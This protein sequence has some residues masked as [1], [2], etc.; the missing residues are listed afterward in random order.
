MKLYT[1]VFLIVILVLWVAAGTYFL[2]F[3]HE[4][5]VELPAL[6]LRGGNANASTEFLNAQKTVDYY[7]EEIKKKPDVIK[8]YIELAQ[9][10]LQEARVTG[11]HHEYIPK[12]QSLLE[13]A[14]KRDPESYEANVTKA[15]M[16]MTMHQFE[17]AKKLAE[18]TV[19]QRPYAAIGY[20]VLCD[21]LVELGMY[22]EAVK[23]C[24]KMMSIRPDLRS[25]ARVSYL[26]ELN[27]DADGAIE[28]MKMAADAAVP[29]QEN[30]AWALYNLG[31]LFLNRGNL[32]TAAY[33]FNGIL[34]ERTDYA[35]AL[36][37]LA[38][39]K[40]AQ[41]K[42]REAVE[43][44]SK[45]SQIMPEHAFV[46]QLAD[47]YRSNGQNESADGVAKIVLNMFDQHEKG[48]WNINREYAM[49]CANHGMNLQDALQ[50]AKKEYDARPNNIDV[51]ETYAWALYKNGKA[52]DAAPFIEQAMRLNS[53]NY[54]LF[55][56]AAMIYSAAGMKE[57]AQLYTDR[58]KTENHFVNVLSIDGRASSNVSK[59]TVASVQ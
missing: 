36:S 28:A 17:E 57:K 8:N 49:F 34:Q 44:L 5:T 29:G 33:I 11:R 1:K 46:E 26:R 39:V 4:K 58:A 16:L 18:W 59:Q 27:G 51:L 6:S 31:K 24:D 12:A 22:D 50:R 42:T 48:G 7:R 10:F 21:A 14:L 23:T 37:G 45:A 2:A 53:R 13:Q 55:N 54:N 15:T 9:L 3:K 30:R 35:F 32:D 40:R 52:N 41:G 19:R 38:Q 20:G 56:H 25:Y 47:V 43:L